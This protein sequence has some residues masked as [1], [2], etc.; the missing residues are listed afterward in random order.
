[1]PT[2]QQFDAARDRE[3]Q[4]TKEAIK[5]ALEVNEAVRAALGLA[6]GKKRIKKLRR[7]GTKGTRKGSIRRGRRSRRH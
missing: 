5:T 2:G 1:M 4:G 7:K 3:M 6:K